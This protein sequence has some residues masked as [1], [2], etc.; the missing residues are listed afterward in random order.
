NV[1]AHV[2]TLTSLTTVQGNFDI[3]NNSSLSHL[4]TL[5]A[6]TT[7]QGRLYFVNDPSLLTIDGLTAL[8][9]LGAG[10]T[11]DSNYR[12]LSTKISA[13]AEINGGFEYGANS[14]GAAS[15]STFDLGHVT[16]VHGGISLHDDNFELGNGLASLQTI[17][18][19]LDVYNNIGLTH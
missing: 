11:I 12:L 16:L 10:I 1:V 3:Y 2:D 14:V 18:G 7:V 4:D 5:P 15:P 17:Q 8:T 6:L 9:S 19:N 13:L